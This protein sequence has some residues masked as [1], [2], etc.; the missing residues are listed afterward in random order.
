[1]TL[2]EFMRLSPQ[3]QADKW[4]SLDPEEQRAFREARKAM[5]SSKE[6]SAPESPVIPSPP[7]SLNSAL[8]TCPACKREVS[9]QA[10]SCPHCGHVLKKTQSATGIL[11]AI[12]IA[13]LIFFFLVL[14][15]IRSF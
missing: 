12:I 6:T 14:P 10:T 11:A 13:L 8:T 5:G 1:M 15:M 4:M 2:Q 3:E 7:V 9:K